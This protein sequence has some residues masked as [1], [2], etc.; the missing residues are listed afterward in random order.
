MKNL[1]KNDYK[2]YII[3]KIFFGLYIIYNEFY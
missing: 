1:N 2:Y 3:S